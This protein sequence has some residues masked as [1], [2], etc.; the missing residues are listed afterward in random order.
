[1]HI[2]SFFIF[3]SWIEPELWWSGRTRSINQVDD[4][5]TIH[6]FSMRIY[7]NFLDDRHICTPFRSLSLSAYVPLAVAMHLVALN[8]L[9]AGRRRSSHH[10]ADRW[11]PAGVDG[12]LWRE[13]CDTDD[14]RTDV[15]VAI[16]IG[17][18]RLMARSRVQTG[19]HACVNRSRS[20]TRT[21]QKTS[22]IHCFGV[23][24]S[25]V[26]PP[27]GRSKFNDGLEISTGLRDRGRQP[28]QPLRDR[29]RSSLCARLLWVHNAEV[30]V[31]L[32][33]LCNTRF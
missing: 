19:Q 1:M 21:G 8:S 9:Y 24:S 2:S 28:S 26:S 25:P 4:A 3:I 6:P 12:M 5:C 14:P 11:K 31:L 7:K 15:V 17:R 13:I 16:F 22:A 23:S 29:S 20:Q 30:Q 27:A 10:P 33:S 32:H 18:V